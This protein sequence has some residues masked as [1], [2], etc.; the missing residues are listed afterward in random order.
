MDHSFIQ[1][2]LK[3]IK[4]IADIRWYN[5]YR[6]TSL[7]EPSQKKTKREMELESWKV[8][9]SLYLLAR[10]QARLGGP[11]TSGTCQHRLLGQFH[12]AAKLTLL[13]FWTVHSVHN[14]TICDPICKYMIIYDQ[15][16]VNVTILYE[17]DYIHIWSCVY[18][19]LWMIIWMWRCAYQFGGTRSPWFRGT[20]SPCFRA[21]SV[22]YS[23][24]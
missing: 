7:I 9:S 17:C 23:I 3:W 16:Y 1:N 2:H 4:P 15:L 6:G 5:L 14:M 22:I 19:I 24:R 21:W 18:Y 10:H 20:S 8:W 13:W 12:L 11:A